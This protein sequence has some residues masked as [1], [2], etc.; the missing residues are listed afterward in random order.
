[1]I[2]SHRMVT[3]RPNLRFRNFFLQTSNFIRFKWNYFPDQKQR[4]QSNSSWILMKKIFSV[5]LPPKKN[6]LESFGLK[7]K[8]LLFNQIPRSLMW[9]YLFVWGNSALI[10]CLVKF[11]IFFCFFFEKRHFDEF[12]NFDF[13]NRKNYKS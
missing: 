6:V 3:N 11:S 5:Y 1:M 10:K 8:N 2:L 9:H 12:V 7:T 4:H 13:E